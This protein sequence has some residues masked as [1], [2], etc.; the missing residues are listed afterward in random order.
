MDPTFTIFQ[1]FSL[2]NYLTFSANAGVFEAYA[3]GPNAGVGA[4]AHHVPYTPFGKA[5]A[6]VSASLGKAGVRAGPVVAEFNPNLDTG[7]SVSTTHVGANF[8]GFG[9]SLGSETSFSTPLGKIGLDF[10]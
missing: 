7:V 5:E 3:E 4:E 9:V 2:K 8:L 6:S 10:F 1:P